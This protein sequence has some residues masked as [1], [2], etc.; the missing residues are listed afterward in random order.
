MANPSIHVFQRAAGILP[1]DYPSQSKQ[2]FTE[3]KEILVE[4]FHIPDD[5]IPAWMFRTGKSSH[6]PAIMRTLRLPLSN[7]LASR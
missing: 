2:L 3:G 1:A 7:V 5:E 6:L 4:A